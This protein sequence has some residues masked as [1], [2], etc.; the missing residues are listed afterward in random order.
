MKDY[1]VM[2]NGQCIGNILADNDSDALITARALYSGGVHGEVTA[3][4]TR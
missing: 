2:Y 1:D 3:T 4:R